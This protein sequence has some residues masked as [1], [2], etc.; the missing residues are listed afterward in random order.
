VK[1]GSLTSFRPDAPTR[2]SRSSDQNFEGHTFLIMTAQAYPMLKPKKHVEREV[3]RAR[4]LSAW[5]K[6][7]DRASTECRVLD[8]SRNGAK[9]STAL[10]SALPDRFELAFFEGGR[11]RSCEVVWRHGKVLGIKFAP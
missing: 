6:L 10:P 8:V 4:H 2:Q 5:I 11:T 3:R 1:E 9:I 7:Q